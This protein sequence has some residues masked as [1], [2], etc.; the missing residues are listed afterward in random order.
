MV[1]VLGHGA[2]DSS[3]KNN[4][5]IAMGKGD[6][7]QWLSEADLKSEVNQYLSP[8]YDNVNVLLNSCYSGNFVN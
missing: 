8:S 2:E 6:G 3:G 1:A 7:D 4:G 5:T